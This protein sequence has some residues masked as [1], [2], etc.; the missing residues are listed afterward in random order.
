[1]FD[2]DHKG[3][4]TSTKLERQERF[5]GH[6]FPCNAIGLMLNFAEVGRRGEQLPALPPPF[7]GHCLTSFVPVLRYKNDL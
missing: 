4:G 6:F 1:M 2:L 5:S 3:S 7:P